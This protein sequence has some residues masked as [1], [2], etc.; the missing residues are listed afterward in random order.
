[1]PK[2]AVLTPAVLA[3]IKVL[4]RDGLSADQIAREV[5]CTLGTL[6]VRCS[7]N[8]ISLRRKGSRRRAAVKDRT[9]GGA[10][11]GQDSGLNGTERVGRGVE[12]RSSATVFGVELTVLIPE[13]TAEQ[14]QQRAALT[15]MTG[16]AL[17]TRLLTTI[18]RDGLY[19]A[20]LDG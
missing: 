2:P 7:Q 19:D 4:V 18:D 14:L 13:A 8:G 15:G 6:R 16:A 20:V 1:M 9:P 3:R 12:T 11:R 17:A 10:V 5:G